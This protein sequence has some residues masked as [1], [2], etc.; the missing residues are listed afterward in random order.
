MPNRVLY[1]V[2][3]YSNKKYTLKKCKDEYKIKKSWYRMLERCYSEPYI[4][5][6]ETYKNCIVSDI[7]HEYE[8][9]REWF[10]KNYIEGYQLDKDL[11]YF[12]NKI[13]SPDACIMVHNDVNNLFREINNKNY[14][15]G[16]KLEYY[17]RNKPV[18]SSCRFPNRLRD[19]SLQKVQSHFWNIKYKRMND[20]IFI[21]PQ[22]K[23]L[24]EN[25]FELFFNKH[26]QEIV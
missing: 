25:Y 2:G 24:L 22:F 10:D 7:W 26:Y 3:F 9:Y 12:G 1:G 11:K 15:F 13:Y 18:Y 6:K 16:T 14:P 23:E 17:A 21:F 20:L 5:K 4:L 8:N 19:H